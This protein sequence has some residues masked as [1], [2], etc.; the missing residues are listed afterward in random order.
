MLDENGRYKYADLSD[1]PAHTL[2]DKDRARHEIAL[3][4]TE[5]Q[6]VRYGLDSLFHILGSRF[7]ALNLCFK[8]QWFILIIK[9][10]YY[11][12]SYNRKIIAPSLVQNEKSCSP[13]FN[14]RY[15]ALYIVVMLYAVGFFAIHFNQFLPFWAY[16][17]AQVVFGLV[18][19]I[20]QNNHEK[21]ITY[22]GHQ[23]TIL[24]IGCLLLLPSFFFSNLLYFNLVASGLVMAREFWRRWKITMRESLYVCNEK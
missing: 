7:P 11:F 1:F 12:I 6:E 20:F 22:L 19:P 21:I 14:L 4:D 3:V 24:L 5:K 8:Q 16:W 10:L 17:V 15:R 23:I 9:H 13:D 2:I 18:S